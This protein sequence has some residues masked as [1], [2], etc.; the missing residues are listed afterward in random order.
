MAGDLN[1]GLSQTMILNLEGV[2]LPNMD[3]DSKSDTFAV[4]FELVKGQK[5]KLGNT[6]VINDNL[7]PKWVQAIEC[8]FSF[9]E[10]QQFMIELYDA[11]DVHNLNNL[12]GQDFM[13]SL[14]F[15]M[16]KLVAA[17]DTTIEIELTNPKKKNAGSLKITGTEKKEGWGQFSCKFS[18]SCEI[19]NSNPLFFTVARADPNGSTFKTV[20]KSECRKAGVKGGLMW[21][22]IMTD[23]D[24]LARTEDNCEV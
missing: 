6:E 19:N 13:G 14:Q 16:H 1:A 12:A 4:L 23:T 8:K 11:D 21:T 2:K 9:E 7:N 3:K 24:T 20:Y 22:S 17:R 5:V 18:V 10:N 15:S